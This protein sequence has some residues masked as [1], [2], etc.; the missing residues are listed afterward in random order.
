M[1]LFL[2]PGAG[3]EDLHLPAHLMTDLLRNSV[4][5]SKSKPVTS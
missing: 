2:R 1:V 5:L 4:P 3:E